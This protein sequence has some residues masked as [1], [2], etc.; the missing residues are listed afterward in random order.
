VQHPASHSHDT[1]I[2][3][4]LSGSRWTPSGAST[5]ITYSFAGSASSYSSEVAA[6]DI[7]RSAFSPADRMLTREL[8]AT[9][10]A[11]CN[12]DFIEVPD[13]GAKPGALRFAYSDYPNKMGFAGYA[14]FPSEHEAGGDVWIGSA[15]AG[16]EWDGY[17]PYLILHETL[18]ALGLKH[19]FDGDDILAQAGDVIPNTVMSYSVAAGSQSGA[20][21]RFPL[22]P[23][24]AD[25]QALQEL[26][27][28]ASHNAGDTRYDLSGAAFQA[29][30]A[31]WDSSGVDTLDARACT[32][33]VL[34]DLDGGARSDVGALIHAF[35]YE[36]PSREAIRS[37][38]TRT[39]AV[40][41]GCEIEN[42]AGSAFDDV[43]LGNDLDNMLWGGAGDDVLDGRGGRDVLRGGGGDDHFHVVR[44]HKT[45]DG[46]AG[47]DTVVFSGQRSDY[48]I[49][50]TPGL[51][52]VSRLADPG[53][54]TTLTG[55]ERVEFSDA[56][57][58]ARAPASV[59]DGSAGQVSRLFKAALDRLPDAPG[60][61]FHAKSLQE[62]TCL[63]DVAAQFMASPEFQGRFGNPCD[64]EF[65]ALLYRNVLEREP[66]VAGLAY[67]VARLESPG[68]TRADVLVGF[69]E[70]P[71]NQAALI[72]L[73]QA[74]LFPV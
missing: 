9:I 74:G 32:Q 13:A 54:V 27:G 61:A 68:T 11:V 73:G 3:A 48:A 38:W 4:L 52:T 16:P 35:S 55:I 64:E 5:T 37:D 51:A 2:A 63:T 7:T 42:A 29:F 40:A 34:L 71:E 49:T 10:E 21:S 65:V 57:L 28:A 66:D 30:R 50:E 20:L 25:V 59:P 53:S 56:V 47:H 41:P 17:R 46:G 14:F 70:S 39:L 69:S 31:L 58:A 60:L 36:G 67:H 12:V 72:G 19:P 43:L 8:L 15:Q 23:M 24:P 44:G 26:Y 45:I 62:G 33:G 1:D 22:E 18:H 6:F